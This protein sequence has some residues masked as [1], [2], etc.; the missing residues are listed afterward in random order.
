[1]Y[2]KGVISFLFGLIFYSN[3][4]INVDHGTFPGA[5]SA[6]LASIPLSK[7][8]FGIVGSIVYLGL[9]SG[10]AVATPIFDKPNLIKPALVSSLFL[11]GISLLAYK[12]TSSLGT[13]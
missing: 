13:V 6:M 2:D 11:N 9:T 5:T 8:E 10:A 4:L 12:F 3:I 1:M 7:T